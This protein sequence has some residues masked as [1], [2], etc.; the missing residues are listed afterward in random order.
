MELAELGVQ[1]PGRKGMAG[2]RSR[3][4]EGVEVG[5]KGPHESVKLPEEAGAGSQSS[6]CRQEWPEP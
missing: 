6:V 1:R 3:R 5:L 2:G 4:V